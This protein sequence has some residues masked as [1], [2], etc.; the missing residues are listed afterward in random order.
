MALENTLTRLS[1]QTDPKQIGPSVRANMKWTGLYSETQPRIIWIKVM[2]GEKPGGGIYAD[3]DQ[4]FSKTENRQ[5]AT[6][7]ETL[8]I[9]RKINTKKKIYKF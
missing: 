6:D 5:L 4:G 2:G 7:H 1:V 9:P 3:T 8:K